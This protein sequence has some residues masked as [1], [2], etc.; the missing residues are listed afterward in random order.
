[1]GLIACSAIL[2]APG[3][4]PQTPAAARPASP[5][6]SPEGPEQAAIAAV[7]TARLDVRGRGRSRLAVQ[8]CVAWFE[9]L[10]PKG[11]RKGYR[12]LGWS[13][14]PGPFGHWIVTLRLVVDGSGTQAEWEYDPKSG[15]IGFRDHLSKFLSFVP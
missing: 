3:A 9:K 8:D 5:P 14:K 7:R 2:S 13:A 4:G 15:T 11:G 12:S 10:H 1:M 6:D